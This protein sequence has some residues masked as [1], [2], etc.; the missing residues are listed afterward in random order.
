MAEI[1]TNEKYCIHQGFCGGCLYGSTPYEEQAAEKETKIREFLE[2][3]KV[4]PEEYAGFDACPME[5]RF[6][7]RNK[8]EYTFGDYIKGG[9]LSLGMH[10]KGHFMSIVTTESC[11]LVDEDFNKILKYAL[12]FSREHGYV[13]Y[14]K[15][16]HEGLLRNLVIRKGIRT[17]ELLIN[18]VTASGEFDEEAFCQGLRALPLDNNIVGILRTINNQVADTIVNENVS[19]IYG[20]DY[21]IEKI[22]NLTFH[23]GAFSFFQT[24]VERAEKLY[25]DAI[26]LIDKVNDK[27]VF[28]LF[29][30][31]GTIS[32]I[33]A[34]GAKKVIGIEIN[35]QAVSDARK[36]AG[37]NGIENCEFIEGDVFKKLKTL[38]E[39]PDVIV[40]DPPRMGIIPKAVDKIASYGVPE[41]LYISCNPKTL[42]PNLA[43]FEELGYK[44]TYLKGYDNFPGTKHTECVALLK[45]EARA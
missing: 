41:I 9:P 18:L 12:D 35:G 17:E 28:D 13:H 19:V 42:A 27:V 21:Y 36:N 11:K 5:H 8:M 40:V 33:L 43:Q 34:L 15:K 44:T 22:N 32:Q 23:V 38:E 6:H 25:S 14:N 10:R 29:S 16:T 24:N 39:T 4:E 2:K 31:T 1:Q 26:Q 20:R 7:Y 3:N 45:K 37:L 30:G